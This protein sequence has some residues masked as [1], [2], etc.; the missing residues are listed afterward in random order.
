MTHSM[1]AA[2]QQ[3]QEA[4]HKYQPRS[5]SSNTPPIPPVVTT[6]E[7]PDTVMKDVKQEKE[8]VMSSSSINSLTFWVSQVTNDRPF[9]Q[10][11][12]AI[13]PS[14]PPLHQQAAQLSQ[15]Q[16][17]TPTPV[18]TTKDASVPA[19]EV[20]PTVPLQP[21]EHGAPF[22]RYLNSKVTPSLLAGMKQLALEQ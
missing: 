12:S 11:S 14:A 5:E 8:Q 20:A 21:V 7:T 15:P 22:R 18:R 13:P 4:I 16:P 10:P 17:R 19:A 2:A 9:F 6:Q 3:Y 1:S